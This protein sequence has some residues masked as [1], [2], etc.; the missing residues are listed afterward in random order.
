MN[1]KKLIVKLWG[2]QIA[3]TT[4]SGYGL[5]GRKAGNFTPEVGSAVS[6]KCKRM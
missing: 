4:L 6:Q 3:G 2:K 5:S 1:D